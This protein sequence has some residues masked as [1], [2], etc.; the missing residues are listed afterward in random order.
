MEYELPSSDGVLIPGN[1][2]K[3]FAQYYLPGGPYPK[4]AVILCHGIPGNERLFDF[5]VYFRERGFCTVNFH[6]SGS[7]GSEGNYSIPHCFEDTASV[8]EYVRKNENGW[9]DTE[10]I[11]VVGHSLGGLM[12]AYAISTF[13]SVKGGALLAPYNV[14][15]D[16]M[17]IVT[18]TGR[19]H[20]SEMFSTETEDFW[21]KGFHREELIAD[22]LKEPERFDLAAY[23]EG[24]AKKPV[25]LATC[26][27]DV[28]SKEKHGGKL[29]SAIGECSADAPLVY[30]EYDTDHGFNVQRNEVKKDVAEFLFACLSKERP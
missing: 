5:S 11:F 15:A 2:G 16:S 20:L 26:K 17:P 30:R 23:A 1:R 19:G 28:F 22:I 13:P 18:E 3:I 6:Y 8:I 24:L 9:F 7:W 12:A 25:F 29:A 10:N 14:L 21:L 4:P 27:K